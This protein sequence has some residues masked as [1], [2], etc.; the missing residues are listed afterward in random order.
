MA[1]LTVCMELCEARRR[2]GDL[3][4]PKPLEWIGLD[5][6]L[7]RVLGESLVAPVALPLE[8]RSRM[9]GFALRS[10]DT[11]DASPEHPLGLEILSRVAAAGHWSPGE[12]RPGECL[13]ILTGAPLPEGC[14]AVLPDE[15]A[16]A[17]HGRLLLTRPIPRGQWVVAP[18]DD[19]RG[20]ETLVERGAILTPSRLAI[21]AALGRSWV[22]VFRRPRAALLAT[23]D[24]LIELGEAASKPAAF[25]NNRL[26][27]AWM[28]RLHEAEAV[29]LGIAPDHAAAVVE[30]LGSA[31][32]D[33]VVTT[34]GIGPGERDVVLDAW[35]TLGVQPLCTQLNLTP[36]KNSA[37]GHRNGQVFCALPGNPWSAQVVFVEL[38]APLIR[39]WQGLFREEP[40][41]LTVE[42]ES[43]VAGRPGFYRALRGILGRRA[44]RWIFT[45][46]PARGASLLTQ[47]AATTAHALLE[48]AVREVSRGELLSVRPHALPQAAWEQLATG[49]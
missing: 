30:R 10:D 25:C 16:V 29:H 4:V 20:A 43:P 48:P 28:A 46:S 41:A 9:D 17:A 42:T 13:R 23:G 19:A 31:A 38:L 39:R 22:G 34:G 8:R 7:G 6:A 26:L 24:E 11:A 14:D 15:E 49:P 45:A 33:L 21:A 12:C 47:M 3:V 32:A 5:E 44:G 18:G 2:L 27:L 36:G 1:R 37:F 35:S 40:L